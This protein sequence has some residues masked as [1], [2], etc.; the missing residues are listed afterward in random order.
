MVSTNKKSKHGIAY[1]LVLYILLFSSLITLLGTI[2]QLYV[3]YRKDIQSIEKGIIQIEASHLQSLINSLWNFDID[4]LK[5]QMEGILQLPGMRYLAIEYEDGMSISV[6][7]PQEVNIVSRQFDMIYK[8]IPGEEYHLGNLEVVF[9]LDG[10]YRRLFDRILIILGTQ[11][12]KTFLVSAFI[13]IIFHFLVTRHLISLAKYTQQLDTDS[14]DFPFHFTRKAKKNGET[15]ELDQVAN[16]LDNMRIKLKNSYSE[17]K[18]NELRIRSIFDTAAE[19]IFTIDS[20]GIIESFNPA[21]ENLF[22]YKADEVKGNAIKMLIPSPQKGKHDE[23]IAEYLRT[24]KS[25]VMGTGREVSGQRKD[26]TIFPMYIAVSEIRLGGNP[27]FTGIAHDLSEQKQKEEQIK[28]HSILLEKAVQN[29]TKEMELITERLIRQEKLATIGQISSSIAHELRN[30]LGAIKQ[31]VFYLKRKIDPSL[32]KEREFLL[33]IED[34]IN[35]SNK[36][37]TNLLGM[38][39]IKEIHQE[40]FELR[41]VVLEAANRCGLEEKKMKLFIDLKNEPFWIWADRLQIRQVLINVIT[42]AVKA[43]PPGGKIFV[44][45]RSLT[46]ENQFEI[47]VRDNGCGIAPGDIDRVFEPLYTNRQKG[48]GLGLSICKQIMEK[49][50]GGISLSSKPEE[51]TNVSIILP[52]N[53]PNNNN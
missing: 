45:G 34:E 18:V 15:D 8:E 53:D 16:A 42:N 37:I 25:K 36:V 44:I 22:L 1:R 23:Y 51:G 24:G 32:S 46:E 27:F 17:L 20:R 31:A 38:T 29:K 30:P 26:G 48:T 5:V 43:S 21:A 52:N 28:N 19:A 47:Q 41:N 39:R 11:T 10:V 50:G 13:L 7:I 6:G 2:L 9:S 40:R 33:L 4:Q 49:H 35:S 12:I 14:L 3:D